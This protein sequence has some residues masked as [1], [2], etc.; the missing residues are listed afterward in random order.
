MTEKIWTAAQIFSPPNP[1]PRPNHSCRF[2]KNHSPG[3]QEQAIISKIGLKFQTPSLRQA[4]GHVRRFSGAY[5][6]KSMQKA[7]KK[8]W[9]KPPAPYG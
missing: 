8:V 5:N 7:I 3:K 2:C 1:Y 6:E 9:D 4:T